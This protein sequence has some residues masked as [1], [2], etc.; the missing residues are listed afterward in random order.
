[1]TLGAAI[2]LGV[3]AKGPVIL[4]HVLPVAL[5][6]PL[7]VGG[8]A[9]PGAWYRGIGVSILVALALVGLWLGPALILGGEAYRGEVLWRQSAGRRPW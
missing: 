9:R 2:A 4:I 8:L 1:M 6:A 5:L 7:W 3:Y